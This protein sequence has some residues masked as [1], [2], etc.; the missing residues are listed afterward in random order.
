METTDP[1]LNGTRR[2]SLWKRWP[3]YGNFSQEGAS[4]REQQNFAELCNQRLAHTADYGVELSLSSGIFKGGMPYNL[5]ISW[6]LKKAE[7][8]AE[9]MTGEKIPKTL[10]PKWLEK[11]GAERPRFS[12]ERHAYWCFFPWAGLQYF[13]RLSTRR[14]CILLC[15]RLS[16]NRLPQQRLR[17]SFYLQTLPP[18]NRQLQIVP[19]ASC[20]FIPY[21]ELMLAFR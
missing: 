17:T 10:L 1:F 19:L 14:F 6:M 5:F 7:E 13:F 9:F 20:R 18:H 2:H 3:R 11:N 15:I 8:I 4:P 12:H 21:H 16:P